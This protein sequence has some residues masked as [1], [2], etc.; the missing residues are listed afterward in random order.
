MVFGKFNTNSACFRGMGGTL[1]F[2]WFGKSL[3][4]GRAIMEAW[5]EEDTSKSLPGSHLIDFDEFG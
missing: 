3:V 1:F 4:S 5:V 2:L